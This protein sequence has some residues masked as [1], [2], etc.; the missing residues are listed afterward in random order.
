[1]NIN[2]LTNEL[3][4]LI[5]QGENEL[6]LKKLVDIAK[7]QR[8][9]TANMIYSLSSSYTKYKKEINFGILSEEKAK[10]FA[11]ELTYRLLNIVDELEEMPNAVVEPEKKEPLVKGEE[12]IPKKT[13]TKDTE[14]G[15]VF[16]RKFLKYALLFL[17]I[18]FIGITFK[19]LRTDPEE[20]VFSKEHWVNIWQGEWRHQLFTAEKTDLITQGFITFRASGTEL[21]GE[22]VFIYPTSNS[23]RAKVTLSNVAINERVLTGNWQTD[24]V[25]PQNPQEGT[26]EFVLS[27]NNNAFTGTYNL[28]RQPGIKH[29]WDGRRQ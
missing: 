28:A 12:T 29:H 7:S 21:E 24:L 16:K 6:V 8:P 1:M 10:E 17:G 27:E 18:L 15:S 2:S 13:S 11:N 3:K 14:E 9:D 20:E 19:Y 4:Q 23:P 5:A 26:F 25:D 22:G